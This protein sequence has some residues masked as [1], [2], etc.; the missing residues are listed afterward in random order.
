[1]SADNERIPIRAGR[2]S[3]YYPETHTARVVFGDKD[4][5]VTY[6]LP[7]IVPNTL[8]NKDE[9]HLDV[10]EHVVCLFLGNGL[11]TGFILGSIYDQK[12][13]PPLGDQ[14]VRRTEFEDGTTMFVDRKNHVVEIKDSYGSYIR[15]ENGNIYIKSAENVYINS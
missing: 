10:G 1:M 2:V 13:R 5:M 12:N 3:A 8:K 11:E 14:D 9:A 7:V 6:T 15:M 4:D